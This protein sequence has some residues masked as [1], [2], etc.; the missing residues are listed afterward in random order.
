MRRCI[1]ARIS[2]VNWYKLLLSE[3]RVKRQC[4]KPPLSVSMRLSSGIR[5]EGVKVVDHTQESVERLATNSFLNGDLLLG[6]LT[7]YVES[8]NLLQLMMDLLLGYREHDHSPE[9]REAAKL[10]IEQVAEF[11]LDIIEEGYEHVQAGTEG[12]SRLHS[13]PG[14]CAESAHR[15]CSH[16]RGGRPRDQ[17]P[18]SHG[19]PGAAL[20]LL[21]DHALAQHGGKANPAHAVQRDPLLTNPPSQ[22]CHYFFAD[23]SLVCGLS[24]PVARVGS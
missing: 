22:S 3:A 10:A 20:L 4:S 6:S 24:C 11:T 16:T 17:H 23:R 18:G 12:W 1:Q 13:P 14:P 2:I 21:P 9:V 19:K 15:L 7:L 8:V 5:D